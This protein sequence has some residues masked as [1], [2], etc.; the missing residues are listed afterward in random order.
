EL[1]VT[2]DNTV[3]IPG[4]DPGTETLP[5]GRLEIFFGSCQDFGVWIEPQD[6]CAPLADQVIGDHEHGLTAQPQPFAFH[7]GGHTAECL[8]GS[9]RMGGKAVPTVQDTCD[10]I[11]LVGTQFDGWVHAGETQVTSVIFPGTDAVEALII[12]FYQA[13]PPLGLLEY[14][15]LESFLDQ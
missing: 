1:G 11:F 8:S 4:S 10:H 7:S 13:F 15:V 5:V 3:V 2:D 9:Y 12:A 6:I 14:P